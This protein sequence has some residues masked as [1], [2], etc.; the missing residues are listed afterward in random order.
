MKT[1]YEEVKENIDLSKVLVCIVGNKSDR[2][3]FQQVKKEEAE[4][5]SKSINGIFRC[6]SALNSYGVKELFEYIGK[7]LMNGTRKKS[8]TTTKVKPVKNISLKTDDNKKRKKEG[9]CCK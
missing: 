9:G 4:N 2:Y 3:N 7:T 1:I 5:Y 8:I 6:V